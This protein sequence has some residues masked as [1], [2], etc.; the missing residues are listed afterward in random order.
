MTI[1][2]FKKLLFKN[3]FIVHTIGIIKEIPK[4]RMDICVGSVVVVGEEE[5][6]ENTFDYIQYE[7]P[8]VGSTHSLRSFTCCQW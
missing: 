5:S 4:T 6:F 7:I 2:N 1:Q 8:I 3:E